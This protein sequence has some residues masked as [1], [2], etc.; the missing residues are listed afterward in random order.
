MMK[1]V[2]G[3]VGMLRFEVSPSEMVGVFCRIIVC[4]VVGYGLY[5]IS[6]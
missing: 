5:G 1:Q 2:Y 4:L 6:A 3:K